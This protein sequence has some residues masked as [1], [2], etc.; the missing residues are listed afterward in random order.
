MVGLLLTWPRLL[1]AEPNGRRAPAPHAAWTARCRCLLALGLRELLPSKQGSQEP[2]LVQTATSL[3]QLAV[4]AADRRQSGL[5]VESA[6]DDVFP[7]GQGRPPPLL[8]AGWAWRQEWILAA[9]FTRGQPSLLFAGL[10]YLAVVAERQGILPLLAAGAR[11]CCWPQRSWVVG[12]SAWPLAR[13]LGWQGIEGLRLIWRLSSAEAELIGLSHR[14][15]PLLQQR[16]TAVG[17]RRFAGLE[18]PS[19]RRTGPRADRTIDQL[20]AEKGIRGARRHRHR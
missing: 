6:P 19:D 13:Y 8:R 5:E 11:P 1:P 15:F 14:L 2:R 9:L 17:P 16:R 3:K 7:G 10:T 18:P 4:A 12:G 20:T